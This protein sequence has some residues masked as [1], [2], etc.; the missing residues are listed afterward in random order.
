VQLHPELLG[1]GASTP[2]A[3]KEDRMNNLPRN[4]I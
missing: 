3:S 2:S 1:T 4:Y